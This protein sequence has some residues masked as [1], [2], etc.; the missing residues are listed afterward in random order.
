MKKI[1]IIVAIVLGILISLFMFASKPIISRKADVPELY[2]DAIASQARGI[3][4]KTLPL[5]PVYI[6]ID[7]F[8]G[9]AVHYTIYYFPFGTMGMSYAESDGFNIEKP[10]TKS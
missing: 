9:S 7:Q 3:Y 10:L 8:T 2:L 1:L 6:S 5:V 4:S